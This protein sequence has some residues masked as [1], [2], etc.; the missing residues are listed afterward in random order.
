MTAPNIINPDLGDRVYLGSFLSQNH[1]FGVISDLDTPDQASMS[2]EIAGGNGFLTVPVLQGRQGA[3]GSNAPL[4]RLQQQV[5]DDSDELPTNLTDDDVDIGKYWIVQEFDDDG[6]VTGSKAYIWYGD[7]YEFFQMGTQGPAGPVPIIAFSIELLDPD[8]DDLE[9]EVVI[10]GDAYHPSVLLKIKAPRGPQ[11]PATNIAD[12]PDVDMTPPPETGDTLVY[13]EADGKWHPSTT[14]AYIPKFYT[15][16]EGS[17]NDVSLAFGTRVP[18]GS[19]L[20]PP[21][22]YDSVPIVF[23]HFRLTGLELDSTPL[24]VG[25]EV[26]LGSVNG[27]LV[28]RGW[29]NITNYALVIPHASTGTAPNDAITPENERAKI[30][31]GATG[32]AATLY[33]NAFNDGVAGLYNF[34]NA[35]A[36]LSVQLN[37]I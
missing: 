27:T 35:G 8:D 14:Q 22:E 7:H 25:V 28:A 1:V 16:P 5:F 37:P 10:T 30:P 2:W 32:A 12:A 6:N 31:A 26:R 19:C 4:L 18:I 36:Q 33:V 15:Y 9:N 29:G 34:E 20:V 24:M 23:G 11:G 13:N 21:Q 3:T 17:F